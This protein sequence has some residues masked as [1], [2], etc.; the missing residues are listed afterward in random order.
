[1]IINPVP[2]KLTQIVEGEEDTV[3]R[4]TEG[5][6]EEV[7][8]SVIIQFVNSTMDRMD[9]VL[10]EWSADSNILAVVEG[11]EGREGR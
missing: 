6:G 5:D 9:R 7:D 8:L 11:E 10:A 1:M 4:A 2:F 3:S